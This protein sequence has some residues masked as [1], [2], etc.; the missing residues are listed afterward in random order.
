MS[1]DAERSIEIPGYKRSRRG[2]LWALA[3]FVV[4]AIAGTW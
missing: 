3:I 4:A 1:F 2:W